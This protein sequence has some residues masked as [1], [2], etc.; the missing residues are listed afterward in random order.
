M[1]VWDVHLTTEDEKSKIGAEPK[2]HILE[3][4]GGAREGGGYLKNTAGNMMRGGTFHDVTG[5]SIIK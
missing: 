3:T 4:K 2:M 5:L 1:S